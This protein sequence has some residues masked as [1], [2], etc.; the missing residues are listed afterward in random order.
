MQ[1]LARRRGC[2]AKTLGAITLTS[3]APTY[4]T[5]NGESEVVPNDP[6]ESIA[7]KDFSA[8]GVEAAVGAIQAGEIK[9]KEFC[10]TIAAGRMRRLF[11][12]P[13]RTADPLLRP[14]WRQPRRVVVA[15][16]VTTRTYASCENPTAT[17]I[18]GARPVRRSCR[19]DSA[20]HVDRPPRRAPNSPYTRWTLLRNFSTSCM[21]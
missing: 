8:A 17:L 2:G 3:S 7:A 13:G 20:N 15:P 10:E 14:H 12:Q 6:I 21:R 11:R 5:P 18:R 19:Y 1:S 9:Y 4:Y 16:K